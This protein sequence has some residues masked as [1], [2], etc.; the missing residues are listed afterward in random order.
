MVK[1]SEYCEYDHVYAPH[2]DDRQAETEQER[3][4]ESQEYARE[5]G[6]GLR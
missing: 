3:V 4:E 2:A 6:R 5:V 1:A